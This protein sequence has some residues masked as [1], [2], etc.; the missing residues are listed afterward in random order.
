MLQWQMLSSESPKYQSCKAYY[1]DTINAQRLVATAGS[2]APCFDLSFAFAD[3]ETAL[4]A[5][6]SRLNDFTRTTKTLKAL[7]T[8]P[9]V[10]A[11]PHT[12][13]GVV[14]AL[15]SQVRG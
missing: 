13:D 4:W 8:S 1:H 11:N 5:A 10:E 7:G 9:T 12:I 6:K 14:E 15:L 3:Q 2:G